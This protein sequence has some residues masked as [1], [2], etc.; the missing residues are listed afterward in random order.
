VLT[1]KEIALIEKRE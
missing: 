1:L